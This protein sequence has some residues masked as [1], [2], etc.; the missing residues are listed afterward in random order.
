MPPLRREGAGKALG[1]ALGSPEAS[2][3]ESLNA[4][5]HRTR[6]HLKGVPKPSSPKL[7]KPGGPQ[8]CPSRRQ[9][10]GGRP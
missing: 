1:E 9:P 7:S 5:P 8:K 2:A 6:C 3:L 4:T 10:L